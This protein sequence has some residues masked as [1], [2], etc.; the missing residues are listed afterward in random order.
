[1]RHSAIVWRALPVIASLCIA[2][3]AGALCSVGPVG[4]EPTLQQ[5]FGSL[6]RPSAPSA[7]NRCLDDGSDAQW[8]T[9]GT[10]S[11][12]IVIELAGFA[13]ENRFGIYDVLD[14]SNPARQFQLFGGSAGA[15]SQAT[16]TF[17]PSGG[18]GYTV[19]VAWPTSPGAPP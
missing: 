2:S 5:V 11:V 8:Q 19:S 17:T 6:V 3:E 15:G 4:S 10:S 16:I 12:T 7:P 13:N 1:M 14:P 9:V 18:G